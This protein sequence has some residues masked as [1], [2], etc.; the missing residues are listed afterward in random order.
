MKKVLANLLWLLVAIAGAWAYATLALHRGEQINSVYMLIA[1]L[2]TYAPPVASAL[3]HVCSVVMTLPVA[4]LATTRD[5]V[6]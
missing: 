6:S 1:A 5:M 3:L 4:G 2:C